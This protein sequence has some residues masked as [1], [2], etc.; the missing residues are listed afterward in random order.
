VVC[1]ILWL[2]WVLY[3][4]TLT[5]DAMNNKVVNL[6]D[7]VCAGIFLV[8]L[9]LTTPYAVLLGSKRYV[10]LRTSFRRCGSVVVR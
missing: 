5:S 2:V 9:L 6:T 8:I 3:P 7:V 10:L 1:L 4:G